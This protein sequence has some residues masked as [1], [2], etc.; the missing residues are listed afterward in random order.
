MGVA[1]S[2]CTRVG[3]KHRDLCMG[4]WNVISLNEKEQELVWEAE[5]YHLD[6]VGIS[7]TKCRGSNTVELNKSWKLF[8]LGLDVTM[9]AQAGVGIFVSPG[10]AHCVTDWIPLGG[11]VCLLKLRP[12][13]RSLCILQVYAPSDEAQHQPFLD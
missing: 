12:Q 8:Y 7:S 4:N 9:S 6:I 11:R 13:E 10:L 3:S 2:I 5:Q 1:H